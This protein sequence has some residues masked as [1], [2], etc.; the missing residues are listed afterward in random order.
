M[1]ERPSGVA[2]FFREQLL[3]ALEDQDVVASDLV[4][5]YLVS[6]LSELASPAASR[7]RETWDTPLVD[8]LQEAMEAEGAER[9]RKW[10]TIGDT[11]LMASGVFRGALLY[12]G[13]DIRYYHSL[14]SAAYRQAAVLHRILRAK[15]LDELCEELGAKLPS[16]SDV[17][18]QVMAATYS[19][20]DEGILTLLERWHQDRPKWLNRLLARRGVRPPKGQQ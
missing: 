8:L 18:D 1:I 7:E 3:E 13:L 6:L 17:L 5:S 16:L 14:G 12:R 11:A 19:H 15:P 4:T 20:G 2:E 9:A 10:R